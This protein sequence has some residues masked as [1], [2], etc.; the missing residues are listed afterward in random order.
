MNTYKEVIK[1][2]GLRI[3]PARVAVLNILDNTDKPLDISSI[4]TLLRGQKLAADQATIYRII[5]NFIE[6]GL[7]T[8][9]QFREKKFYYET[10]RKEHHHAICQKC[11][12]IQDVTKCNIKR[13]ER[14]IEKN[15]NFKVTSHSLEFFG[16]CALCQ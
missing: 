11:G 10:K 15:M 8:R 3:T 2:H 13:L 14:E 7:L 16:V 9:L 4:L 6:R 5:E 1:K 12:S